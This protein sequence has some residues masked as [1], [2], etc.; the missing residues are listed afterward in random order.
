MLLWV[1][2]GT[3]SA[4][5]PQSYFPVHTPD[6]HMILVGMLEKNQPGSFFRRRLLNCE[7]NDYVHPCEIIIILK[8]K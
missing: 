3:K 5:Q 2:F 8:W 4:N 6:C 7:T 1:S